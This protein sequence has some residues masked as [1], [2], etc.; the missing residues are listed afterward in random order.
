MGHYLTYVLVPKATIDVQEQL[1]A[2][3]RTRATKLRRSEEEQAGAE[4]DTRMAKNMEFLQAHCTLM[5]TFDNG[6]VYAKG[7][8]DEVKVRM[9]MEPYGLSLRV[10]EYRCVCPCIFGS[11]REKMKTLPEWPATEYM[12]KFTKE[13]FSQEGFELSWRR[14]VL[15]LGAPDPACE[16]CH[17]SGIK[18][19]QLNP[20]P[21]WDWWEIGS[22]FTENIL[23]DCVKG[24]PGKLS[25]VPVCDLDLEK[26]P[27]PEHVI[28][29][30]GKCIS[31][32]QYLRLSNALVVDEHW[33][34]TVR[35]VLEAHQDATLVVVNCH[36]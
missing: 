9:L 7:I 20:E 36:F 13:E 10:S 5:E 26:L 25:M 30:D 8:P 15:E 2:V 32:E 28:T 1:E 14:K 34:E 27:R 24:K 11:A 33:E 19:C 3:E 22:G 18:I 35:A 31:S 29:P 21:L 23:K 6:M 4:S 17:G 16:D 12:F